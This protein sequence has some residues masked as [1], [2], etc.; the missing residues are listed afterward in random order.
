MTIFL[1]NFEPTPERLPVGDSEDS[2]FESLDQVVELLGEPL[3]RGKRY[4]AYTDQ[5]YSDYSITPEVTV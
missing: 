4:V 1:T 5:Y 3:A 2:G